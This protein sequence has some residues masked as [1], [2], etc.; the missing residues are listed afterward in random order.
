MISVQCL[1][2]SDAL[3]TRYGTTAIASPDYQNQILPDEES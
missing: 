1:K 2:Q 3:M